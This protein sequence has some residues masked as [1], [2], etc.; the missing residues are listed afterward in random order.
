VSTPLSVVTWK[1]AP[2]DG[3]RSEFTAK[4]VNVL[5]RMV[6]RCYP[7]PHRFICVTDDAEGIDT[8]VEVV[9]L[10]GE[11]ADL[12]SPAG[13]AKKHP[14]C[15]RRLRAFHPDIASIF[16][17]RF[18]SLDLDVVLTGDVRSLWDRP[19]PFVCYG[20]THKPQHYNG[21]MVLMTAG[22]RPQVWTEFNPLKSPAEAKAAGCFGSDQGWITHVLGSGEP[23]WGLVDGV[24]SFRNHLLPSGRLPHEARVVIFHGA[25]KPWDAHIQARYPWVRE[26]WR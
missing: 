3:Y 23:M 12:P 2:C 1:W 19:E 4:T 7:A 22:A 15:Y 6:S 14:S 24:Y 11:F 21:S 9:P 8:E 5:R 10:W 16:G 26:H 13:N 25:W 18:V 20:G 17:P